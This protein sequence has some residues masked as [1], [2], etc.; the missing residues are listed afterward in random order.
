[1]EDGNQMINIIY[2]DNHLLVVEKPVNIIVQEDETKDKDLLT[3]LKEYLREKYDIVILALG[4]NDLQRQYRT[5]IE[6]LKYGMESLVELVKTTIP[7][8]TIILVSPSII[9]EKVL[10]SRIFSFLFDVSSIEK[11]K[12]IASIYNEIAM[13]KD[14]EFLD[15]EQIAKVSEIDGL[16]YDE[17]AHKQ[18]ADAFF[19]IISNLSR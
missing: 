16:H 14:C 5:S 2:E 4:A 3:I 15:L 6:E 12:Y 18:I 19:D 8:S 13:A 17:S 9:G 11:S 10:L 7:S 1:M